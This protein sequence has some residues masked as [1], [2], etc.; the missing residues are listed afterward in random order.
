MIFL[1]TAL[2]AFYLFYIRQDLLVFNYSK[3]PKNHNFTFTKKFEEKN[4]KMRDGIHLNS[5]L[6]KIENS[7]GVIMYI[8]GNAG[9]I[10]FYSRFAKEYNDLG[11]DFFIYDYRG[12]GKSGGR[13]DSEKELYTDAQTVYDY[14]KSLYDEKDIVIAGFSI[15]TGI[16]SH[17]ASN[18]NQKLLVLIAPYFNFMNLLSDMNVYF[19]RHILKYKFNTNLFLPRVNSPILI[20]HGDADTT[21]NIKNSEKLKNEL[22]TKVELTILKDGKHLDINQNPQL[23]EKLREYLDK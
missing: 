10:N 20:F 14:L 16:A 17:L 2:V 23:F 18:N 4:I 22:N 1:L 11:H 7:K 19:L 3:L 8:H 13:I 12:F 21:I 15:G 5:V 9:M 6:F